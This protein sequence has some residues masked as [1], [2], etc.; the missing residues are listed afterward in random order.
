LGDEYARAVDRSW[1]GEQNVSSDFVS[2]EAGEPNPRYGIDLSWMYRPS[3]WIR[4]ESRPPRLRCCEDRSLVRYPKWDVIP[5]R[6]GS[7]SG[8]L[9]AGLRVE[10]CTVEGCTFEDCISLLN[11]KEMEP[12]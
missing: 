10:G 8:Q 9:S 12:C 1:V 4:R 5:S 7:V 6:W 3:D 2:D 11:V